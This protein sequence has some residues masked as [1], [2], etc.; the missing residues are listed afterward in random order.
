M[1]EAS[2][3]TSNPVTEKLI[4]TERDYKDYIPK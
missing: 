3:L 2:Q 4:Q 1:T